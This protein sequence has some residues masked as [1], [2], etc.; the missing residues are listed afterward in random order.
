MLGLARNGGDVQDFQGRVAVVTGAASGIGRALAARFAAEGMKLVLADV[1]PAA[2]AAAG[3]ELQKTGCQTL[4]VE[5]DVSRAEQVEALA[6]RTLDAFGAVH[7]VC[8]NAGVFTG[9]TTWEAPLA[10]YEWVMGVNLWGVIHGIRSFVPILLAQGGEGHVVNTASMAAVTTMPYAGIYHMS[11]HAVLALS[12]CLHH[13]L[14][15]RGSQVRVSALCPELVATHIDTAERNR[16]AHLRSEPGPGSA[17]PERE[18][19]QKAIA[20]GVASGTPP[21]KIADRVLAAIREQRFYVLSDDGWRRSSE[22]R[23]E[24]IRLARNP[25]L[26]PPVAS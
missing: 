18:L 14:V 6:R 23:S 5:T 16:P 11:K 10:D 19:V 1:E 12:E 9:G 17:S 26:A 15:L 8:N 20:E 13:E 2:L 21:A 7:V 24:D 25:T 22:V 4:A 3:R